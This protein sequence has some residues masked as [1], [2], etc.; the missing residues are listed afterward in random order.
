MQILA[1]EASTVSAKA[2]LYDAK[3]GRILRVVSKRYPPPVSDGITQDLDG[4]CDAVAQVAL[5]AADSRQVD[6]V[7]LC[8]TWHAVAVCGTDMV[9][10]TRAYTWAY[11]GA[12]AEAETLKCDET[13]AWAVYET[14]GCVPHGMLPLFK[15]QH[16]ASQGY[17]LAGKRFTDPGS[18]LFYRL[19][20]VRRVSRS[21]ASGSGLLDTHTREY[22]PACLALAGVEAEQLGPLCEYGETAPLNRWGAEQLGQKAGIPVLPA[23]PDGALNQLGAGAMR[24]G[25]MTLSVGTSG[26][27][28]MV[29]DRPVLSP[30]RAT[31]CYLAPLGWLAGAATSGACNCVDWF[32]RAFFGEEASYEALERENNSREELPVFLPFLYGERSPGWHSGRWGSFS[33]LRPE[34]TASDLYFSIQEGVAMNLR[35]CYDLLIRELGRPEKIMLSG[36]ILHS[37]RWTQLLADTLNVPL[38]VSGNDQESLLGG[39]LLARSVLE[40]DFRPEQ[41]QP[42]KGQIFTPRPEGAALCQKRYLRYLAAYEGMP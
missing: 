14:T 3:S 15:L 10:E 12:G 11:T 5:E 31:W 27:L 23:H 32:R 22:A 35:Q 6:A 1:L 20:G 29:V 16:F 17:T 36:G 40:P 18:Y 9:P 7:S 42:A 13:R 4:V 38:L 33:D 34:H 19:T 21:M 39:A 37:T 30:S 24:G 41:R 2:M 8:G 28:R 25:T 26:A